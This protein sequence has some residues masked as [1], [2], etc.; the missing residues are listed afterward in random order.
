MFAEGQKV[1]ILVFQAAFSEPFRHCSVFSISGCSVCG[2]WVVGWLGENWGS[3]LRRT[4][5]CLA[6][7]L[8]SPAAAHYN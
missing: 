4:K 1:H 2:R 7:S 3:N 8:T 6:A 5:T